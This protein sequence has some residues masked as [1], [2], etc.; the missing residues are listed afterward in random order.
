MGKD[1]QH[2]GKPYVPKPVYHY[3]PVH[4]LHALPTHPLCCTL[5][6]LALLCIKLHALPH[7][8]CSTLFGHHPCVSLSEW[9]Q[10]AARRQG[11]LR[12][13]TRACAAR[14]TSAGMWTE[15]LQHTAGTC[16]TSPRPHCCTQT[17]LYAHGCRRKRM[18][19]RCAMRDSELASCTT[20]ANWRASCPHRTRIQHS[21]ALI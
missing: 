13:A 6:C 17:R 4:S 21:N 19:S 16:P 8:L 5:P 18:T 7:A 14:V 12:A 11:H 3:T 10:Q 9:A 1:S 20:A 15:F 2:L